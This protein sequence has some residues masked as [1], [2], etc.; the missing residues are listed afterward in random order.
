MR[1]LPNP[2]K[3]GRPIIVMQPGKHKPSESLPLD[4]MKLAV[5]TMETAIKSVLLPRKV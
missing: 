1:L 5:Y 2:D 4:V 3:T